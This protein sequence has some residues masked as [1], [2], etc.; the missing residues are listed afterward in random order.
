MSAMPLP[1]SMEKLDLTGAN[2]LERVLVAADALFPN[3]SAWTSGEI[4]CGGG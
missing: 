2:Q 1:D 4:T 3:Y